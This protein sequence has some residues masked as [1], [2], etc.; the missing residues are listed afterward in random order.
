ME[1]RS[2]AWRMRA[3]G[4]MERRGGVCRRQPFR[5]RSGI[6]Q[7]AQQRD[8]A[9][10]RQG[11]GRGA[12]PRRLGVRFGLRFRWFFRAE[13]GAPAPAPTRWTLPPRPW[14][15][16]GGAGGR[17]P[18]RRVQ[19][20]A[21]RARRRSLLAASALPEGRGGM[22]RRARALAFLLAALIAAAAAAAIADGYGDSVVRGYGELRPV[23]VASSKLPAG[24]PIDPAV[25]AEK[26]EVRRVPVRF[27]PPGALAAPA[28]TVGLVPAASI[29]AGSY[30]LAAQLRAPHVSGPAATLGH[31]RRP[32]EI[33]VSGAGALAA[34]GASPVGSSVDVVTTTDPGGSGGG[35][36]YVA[37][38]AAPLLGVGR[39][40]E[41]VEG[42]TATPPLGLPRKQP[43]R[44]IAAESFARRITLIP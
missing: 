9:R 1:K 5:A 42:E 16:R 8:R 2:G 29:P 14:P 33:A 36:T 15:A 19:P 12:L 13:K 23:L 38:R 28:E 26:L 4:A 22:S 25:A 10:W 27:A 35:R 21:L 40:G 17:G 39:G 32:V 30:L 11:D 37:A 41:G 20:A 3:G 24:K 44:L 43:L 6:G 34:M 7:P 18:R 31:G